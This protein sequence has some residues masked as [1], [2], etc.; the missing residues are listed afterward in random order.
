MP[1][2]LKVAAGL[3]FHFQPVRL[4]QVLSEFRHTLI[5]EAI[6]CGKDLLVRVKP[7]T[8]QMIQIRAFKTSL[9]MPFCLLFKQ[10]KEFLFCRTN[11]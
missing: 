3:Q 8:S 10:K 11:L 5:P 6:V 2:L 7:A 9:S 1:H 4:W